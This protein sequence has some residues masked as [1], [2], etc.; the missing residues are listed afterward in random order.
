MNL[1]KDISPT[2]LYNYLPKARTTRRLKPTRRT[3]K[4]RK[5]RKPRTARSKMRGGNPLE[6][7]KAKVAELLNTQ[8]ESEPA[9]PALVA[10]AN[11]IGMTV[12]DGVSIGNLY[13]ALKKKGLP[14][15]QEV[16]L[17]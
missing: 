8:D 4:S 5:P 1:E 6:V 15:D 12:Q 14:P 16:L 9:G 7:L 17:R 13:N 11:R 2:G 10:D 3:R